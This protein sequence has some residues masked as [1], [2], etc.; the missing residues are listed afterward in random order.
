[1]TQEVKGP[2]DIQ[3]AV[4]MC[5]VRN[6]E[7]SADGAPGTVLGSAHETKQAPDPQGAL[8]SR[9]RGGHTNEVREK[10]EGV[11]GG[12]RWV[13]D[14]ALCVTA[15]LSHTSKLW[16]FCVRYVR[17]VSEIE[18]KPEPL[19]QAPKALLSCGSVSSSQATSC[20]RTAPGG[21]WCCSNTLHS[22]GASVGW[23]CPLHVLCL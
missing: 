14:T 21:P 18:G 10:W 11:H 16:F 3:F 12:G 6:Q 15:F 7:M 9:R 19:S 13:C 2:S 20:V 17:S 5:L 4:R 22:P 23:S 8:F 1:M